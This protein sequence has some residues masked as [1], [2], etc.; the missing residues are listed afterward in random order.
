[1]ASS[2][3]AAAWASGFPLAGATGAAAG[4]VSAAAVAALV[5]AGAAVLAGVL[6]LAAPGAGKAYTPTG[7][8]PGGSQSMAKGAIPLKWVGLGAESRAAPSPARAG[9]LRSSL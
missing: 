4:F 3:S 2:P 7:G 8:D 1:M 9:A 6:V 5:L